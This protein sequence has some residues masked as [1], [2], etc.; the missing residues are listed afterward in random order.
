MSGTLLRARPSAE[1][2]DPFIHPTVH[3]ATSF[4]FVITIQLHT[5]FKQFK[6]VE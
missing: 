2:V 1:L 4:H 3:P 5:I 6:T